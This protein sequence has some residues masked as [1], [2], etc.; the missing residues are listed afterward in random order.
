MNGT[1]MKYIKEKQIEFEVGVKDM[2]ARLQKKYKSARLMYG[3]KTPLQVSVGIGW[4]M[5]THEVKGFGKVV[6][7][8]GYD[9]PQAV[10]EDILNIM[11]VER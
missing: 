5:L 7:R 1:L 2:E 3:T 9:D 4:T 11:G 10:L 6:I 8:E